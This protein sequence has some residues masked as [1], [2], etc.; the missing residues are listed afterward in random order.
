MGGSDIERE[1]SHNQKTKKKL[2][3][4]QAKIQG[5]RQYH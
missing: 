4:K 5:G 1:T 2:L 3:E